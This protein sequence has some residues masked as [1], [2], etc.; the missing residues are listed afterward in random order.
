MKLLVVRHAVAEK[1]GTFARTAKPDDLRPL[2][3]GGQRKMRRAVSALQK[4]VPAV[5]VLAS[6]PLVR[7]E[8]TAEIIA[9]A[10]PESIRLVAPELAPDTELPA[11]LGWLRRAGDAEVIAGVGHE[12]HLS[13]LVSWLLAGRITSFIELKK[14]A[15]CLLEFAGEIAAGEA[16]LLWLLQPAQLRRMRG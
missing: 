7:A 14:G 11:F 1:P 12:P 4:L 8:Q 6:S 10:Y 2:T 15:A 16:R 5:D 9:Q 3:A 13:H